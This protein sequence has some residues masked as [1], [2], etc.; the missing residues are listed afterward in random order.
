MLPIYY[1]ANATQMQYKFTIQNAGEFA[2]FAARP[3]TADFPVAPPDFFHPDFKGS[4]RLFPHKNSNN[5]CII[6]K[7][8]V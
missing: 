5:S 7:I 1:I 4:I 8:C 2:T 6:A 3:R